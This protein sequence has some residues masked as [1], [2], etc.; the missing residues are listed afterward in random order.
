MGQAAEVQNKSKARNGQEHYC[1]HSEQLGNSIFNSENICNHP[2]HQHGYKYEYGH[3]HGDGHKNNHE[4]RRG[5]GHEHGDDHGHVDGHGGGHGHGGDHGETA[6]LCCCELHV[7]RYGLRATRQSKEG[8][9]V[10]GA[11]RPL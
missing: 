3:G 11:T 10:P 7:D 9:R 1:Q 8:W 6:A 4:H 5:H 2:N